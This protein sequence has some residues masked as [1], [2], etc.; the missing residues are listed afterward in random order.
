MNYAKANV[1][2]TKADYWATADEMVYMK[3]TD[4]QYPQYQGAATPKLP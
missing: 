1:P 4:F 3:G 2:S